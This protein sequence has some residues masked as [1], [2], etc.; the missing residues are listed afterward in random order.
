MRTL[1]I[2]AANSQRA[3]DKVAHMKDRDLE[4]KRIFWRGDRIEW[5]LARAFTRG[6][7]RKSTKGGCCGQDPHYPRHLTE[8]KLIGSRP[9]GPM[10]SN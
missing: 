10:R 2:C 7:S 1:P 4:K 3:R 5:I 6:F 9:W 8:I